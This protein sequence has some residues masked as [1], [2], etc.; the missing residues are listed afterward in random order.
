MA[1][2]GAIACVPLAFIF[3]GFLHLKSAQHAE[4]AAGGQGSN[5]GLVAFGASGAVVALVAALANWAD[6]PIKFPVFP[7]HA[8]DTFVG[9]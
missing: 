8:N 9:T 4:S 2:I 3:P 7:R 5:Y 6:M 1:V